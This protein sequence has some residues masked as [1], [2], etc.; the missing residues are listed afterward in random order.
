MGKIKIVNSKNHEHGKAAWGLFVFLSLPQVHNWNILLKKVVKNLTLWKTQFLLLLL[1]GGA[2]LLISLQNPLFLS[3]KAL[4][5]SHSLF[6][7]S[8]LTSTSFF[9][10]SH[11]L[12][13]SFYLSPSFYLSL[14][15]SFSS[16]TL[17]SFCL[18]STIIA[19]SLSKSER[20]S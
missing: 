18:T 13:L 2:P 5:L 20:E 11:S 14:S 8:P 1:V 4:S 9:P 6:P 3:S 17:S 19:K 7:S 15:L 10:L 12:S 16:H